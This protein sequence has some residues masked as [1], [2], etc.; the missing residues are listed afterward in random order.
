[1]SEE[2]TGGDLR[3]TFNWFTSIKNAF[4]KGTAQELIKYISK[5]ENYFHVIIVVAKA[6]G[7]GESRKIIQAWRNKSYE[8]NGVR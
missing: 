1:M 6:G 4:H 5:H 7:P 3:A 2:R 8:L